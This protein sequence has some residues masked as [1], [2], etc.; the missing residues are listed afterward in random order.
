MVLGT[1]RIPK[2]SL[3]WRTSIILDKIANTC[4]V[5]QKATVY[6]AVLIAFLA[7]DHGEIIRTVVK[8]K[9]SN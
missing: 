6:R 3:K 4:V 9:Q 7:L 2:V 8:G 1:S 5:F